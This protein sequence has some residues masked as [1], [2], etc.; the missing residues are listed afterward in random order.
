MYT[1]VLEWCNQWGENLEGHVLGGLG[2]L[3]GG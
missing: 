2:R 3:L 1:C